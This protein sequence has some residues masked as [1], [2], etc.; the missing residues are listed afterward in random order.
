MAHDIVSGVASMIKKAAGSAISNESSQ[1]I[2]PLDTYWDARNHTLKFPLARDYKWKIE[3][4]VLNPA[5]FNLNY[6]SSSDLIGNITSNIRTNIAAASN[7]GINKLKSAVGVAEDGTSFPLDF[8]PRVIEASIKLPGFDTVSTVYQG[9]N[10]TYPSTESQ[11]DMTVN[12]WADE[13]GYALGYYMLWHNRMKNR[14]GTMNYPQQ[15]ERDI[16]IGLYRADNTL[17]CQLTAYGAYPISLSEI[18]LTSGGGTQVFKSFTMT[19]KLREIGIN[20]MN[21]PKPIANIGDQIIVY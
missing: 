6:D 21:Q 4:P 12:L 20:K 11:G 1:L 9:W 19:L 8:V 16:P 3:L 14:D 18:R 17:A 2:T 15:Y 13:N 10:Y 5:K 7:Y